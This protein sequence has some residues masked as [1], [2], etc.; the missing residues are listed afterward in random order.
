MAAFGTVRWVPVG[1]DRSF[2]LAGG[3]EVRALPLG[4]APPRY[5]GTTPGAHW[6]VAYRMQHHATGGVA[7]YAPGV[8]KWS[9]SLAQELGQEAEAGGAVEMVAE[10]APRL[11]ARVAEAVRPLR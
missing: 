6:S 3:V 7:I 10:A 4:G 8:G 1:T 2:E 9:E 11:A 5:V